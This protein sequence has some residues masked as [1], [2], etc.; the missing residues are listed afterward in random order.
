M[1]AISLHANYG[2]YDSGASG[3]GLAAAY[4]L[5]GGASL[6]LGY[7]SSDVGGVSSDTWSFGLAMSF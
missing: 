7:G 6:N 4:D 1:D 5:G 3:F 2:E